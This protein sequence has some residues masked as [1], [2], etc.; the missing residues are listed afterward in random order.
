MARPC[1]AMARLMIDLTAVNTRLTVFRLIPCSK[2]QSRNLAASEVAQ[3]VIGLLPS[4]W[5]T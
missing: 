1:S 3:E 4:S 2:H 5:A